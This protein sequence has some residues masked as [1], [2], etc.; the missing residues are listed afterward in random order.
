MYTL[1]ILYMLE[2]LFYCSYIYTIALNPPVQLSTGVMCSPRL[3]FQHC[4]VWMSS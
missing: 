4:F 1:Y 2:D 3:T